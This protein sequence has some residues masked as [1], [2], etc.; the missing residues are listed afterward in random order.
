[1]EI[2]LLDVANPEFDEAVEYYNAESPCLGFARSGGKA[3]MRSVPPA[4]AG[5]SLDR[6]L[7]DSLNW[8][9]MR[10]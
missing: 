2:R 4:V 5:G 1:M 10:L 8:T 7:R 3:P 9:K 6:H